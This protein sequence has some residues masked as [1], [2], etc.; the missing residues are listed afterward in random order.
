VGTFCSINQQ[1]IEPFTSCPKFFYALEFPMRHNIEDVPDLIATRDRK[2][3][4]PNH[5]VTVLTKVVQEQ[6]KVI[7]NLVRKMELLEQ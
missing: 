5:I 7:Q 2:S 4:T 1:I 3:I 6:Q